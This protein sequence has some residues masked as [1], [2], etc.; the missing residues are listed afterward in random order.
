MVEKSNV[1]PVIEMSKMIELHRSF[2]NIQKMIE[3]EHDRQSKA[4]DVLAGV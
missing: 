1:K 2:N 3:A 4:F